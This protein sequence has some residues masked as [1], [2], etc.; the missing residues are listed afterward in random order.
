MGTSNL[1][2]T[3]HV[4]NDLAKKSFATSVLR[5][6]KSYKASWYAKEKKI[7]QIHR[8][9][10]LTSDKKGI[11]TFHESNNQTHFVICMW[12]WGKS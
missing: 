6:K 2:L 9:A 10:R 4:F 5:F 1:L 11:E 7:E 3:V 8:N 12:L